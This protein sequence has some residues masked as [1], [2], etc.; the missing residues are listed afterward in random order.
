MWQRLD[1]VVIFERTA[2][3]GSGQLGVGPTVFDVGHELSLWTASKLTVALQCSASRRLQIGPMLHIAY[4]HSMHGMLKTSKDK[5]VLDSKRSYRI[6][7]GSKR[8]RKVS[9]K[10]AIIQ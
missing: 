7:E 5:E 6:H 10:S 2:D 8:F 1:F 4:P 9:V 3:V